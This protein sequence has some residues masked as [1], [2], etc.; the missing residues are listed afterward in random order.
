MPFE[1][2][3]EGF[4][5]QYQ[6]S[7]SKGQVN[8]WLDFS[9]IDNRE[10]KLFLGPSGVGKTYLTIELS[11]EALQNG[12]KVRYFSMFDFVEWSIIKEAS[13][14][15][16]ESIKKVLRNNLIVLDEIVGGAL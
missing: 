7:I 14:I 11:R 10:N 13:S 16:K 4:D 9:W 3:L 6:T 1:K 15:S 12:Y 5:F 8:G 2:L